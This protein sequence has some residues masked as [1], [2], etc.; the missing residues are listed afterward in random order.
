M[1]T[2]LGAIQR[3]QANYSQNEQNTKLSTYKLRY[4]D[5]LN[6]FE[7]QHEIFQSLSASRFF[8]LF[9]FS[10]RT[11]AS[12]P[13]IAMNI[14]EPELCICGSQFISLFRQKNHPQSDASLMFPQDQVREAINQTE[15]H[16]RI[17]S[18]DGRKHSI[19]KGCAA[20]DAVEVI[21]DRVTPKGWSAR[22]GTFT[23]NIRL[24]SEGTEK[25]EEEKQTNEKAMKIHL[26]P[27][28]MFSH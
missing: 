15:T 23:V 2:R 16:F 7:T 1:E 13:S 28:D 8:S 9:D 14:N 26:P 12:L 18:K 21:W 25:M 19:A 20:S 10:V 22:S 17:I 11:M 27:K 24:Q 4:D 5:S 3:A 6:T